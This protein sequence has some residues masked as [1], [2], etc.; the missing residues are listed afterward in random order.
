VS[1]EPRGATSA[2]GVPQPPRYRIETARLVIR[3]WEPADAPRM[4]HAVD[5]S[6]EHLRAWMPWAMDEPTELPA[7]EERLAHFRDEFLAGHD[8]LFAIFD[9]DERELLGGT[10]LHQRG[11][12]GSLEIGYWLR[13]DTTGRGYITEST[14]ALV[15]EAF[16]VCGVE[17]VFIR[18][19]ARN[20]RSAAV[21]R[22]LGFVLAETITHDPAGE[23]P[24]GAPRDTL[25][26]ATTRDE[27]RGLAR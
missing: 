3:S 17:R 2:E 12:A 24:D 15:R 7:L 26:W 21:P 22:R 4:K 11:P 6:L 9:R 14:D 20:V 18:C 5:E 16:D 8:F 23:T 27:Y 10:G 13:A 1:D 19:D 25:V